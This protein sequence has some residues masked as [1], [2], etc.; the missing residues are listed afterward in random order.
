MVCRTLLSAHEGRGI[1]IADRNTP[2]VRA[3]L[4]T[5]YVPKRAEY[6]VHV[7]GN[8]SILVQRKVRKAG[9]DQEAN[10]KVRNTANGFIFQRNNIN[11]PQ[12]VIDEAIKAVA[13]CHLDFGAVDVIWNERQQR[14][15]V[16]EVN[17]A[18]GIEGSTVKDYA[19]ALK[20]LANDK[21]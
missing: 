8:R 10:F 6:R 17:T 13:A 21:V 16:L 4:Y 2:L 9:L 19:Q 5:Q 14:A 7:V 20:E 12:A 1:V 3:S 15:Y 11:P 18:P